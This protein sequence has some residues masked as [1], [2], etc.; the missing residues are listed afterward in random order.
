MA[1]CQNPLGGAFNILG[2]GSSGT[3]PFHSFPISNMFLSSGT[4]ITFDLLNTYSDV[5]RRS[6]LAL[7]DSSSS[8]QSRAGRQPRSSI[9][10]GVPNGSRSRDEELLIKRLKTFT[11]GSGVESGSAMFDGM[12]GKL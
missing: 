1:G 2:V 7:P 11:G 4:D 12:R 8:S 10:L 5:G 3:K 9:S 6:G